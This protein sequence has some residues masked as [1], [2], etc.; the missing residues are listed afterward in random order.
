M[1]IPSVP[2]LTGFFLKI[3]FAESRSDFNG[4]TS[5][6]FYCHVSRLRKKKKASPLRITPPRRRK[7]ANILEMSLQRRISAVARLV[8][9]PWQMSQR[10]AISGSKSRE[11]VHDRKKRREAEEK[12][13]WY[14]LKKEARKEKKNGHNTKVARLSRCQMIAVTL[15]NAP[16]LL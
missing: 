4:A 8:A 3:Y 14:A 15:A 9:T 2:I 7:W 16:M 1:F 10:Y 12:K 5:Q 13:K 6:A 11:P